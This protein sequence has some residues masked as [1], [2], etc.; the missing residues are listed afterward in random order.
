[1]EHRAWSK[2]HGG[3]H[4]LRTTLDLTDGG[5]KPIHFGEGVCY[6]V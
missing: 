6:C 1:M 3:R 2:E 5:P 4:T